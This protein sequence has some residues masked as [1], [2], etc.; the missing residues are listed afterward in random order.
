MVFLEKVAIT[1][2]KTSLTN[3]WNLKLFES[4]EIRM[5]FYFWTQILAIS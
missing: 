2:S 1:F 3:F 5:D 4:F